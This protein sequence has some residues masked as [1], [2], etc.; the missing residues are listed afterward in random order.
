MDVITMTRELGKTL[1]ADERMI[2]VQAASDAN[3]ADKELGEQIEKFNQMRAEINQE[4]MKPDKD[5][6]KIEKLDAEFKALYAAI[7]ARPTMAEFSDAK[8]DADKLLGFIMQIINASANGIDP[9]TV[10]EQEE[11]C[12][13]SCSSCKGC[14]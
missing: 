13:G 9:Y 3:D 12:G 14:H 10:E 2:R 6:A 4:V 8:A 11:G 7:M 5:Q 1:Q